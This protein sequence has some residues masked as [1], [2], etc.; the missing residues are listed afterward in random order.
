MQVSGGTPDLSLLPLP[1]FRIGELDRIATMGSCFAQHLGRH[2]AA[3]GLNY[4]FTEPDADGRVPPAFS[5]NYGNVYTVRQAA[6]LIHRAEVG[7]A[8]SG[9]FWERDGRW[10]DA[11]RPLTCPTGYASVAEALDK[12]SRHLANVATMLH[13]ADVLVFTLG[14]TE[15]WMHGETGIVYPSAPGVIAGEFE[16]TQHVFHNFSAAEV[17]SELRSLVERLREI[18]PR[19]RVILTVSPVSL[20][21]T[22]E[23]RHV[24]VSTTYS[25]AA[26]RVAADVAVHEFDHVD[27][28]PSFEA[29]T[30]PTYRYRY[31][32]PDNRSVE[33]A[34][35]RH[36]M[37][38]FSQFLRKETDDL[39]AT[40]V[41][42]TAESGSVEM[43]DV[44]CDEGLNQPS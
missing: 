28:L 29:I 19:M 13:E 43:S 20:A 10:F 31:L 7:D 23:N 22:Y 15:A 9:E 27:Y 17:T 3:N 38:L 44:I 26:L 39:F 1:R 42:P 2:L 25:K 18:N 21:A 35:V 6:Q 40:A 37:R 24:W 8:E 32:S 14:L 41:V 16:P 12:R 4:F 11:L 30:A 33:P 36:A 34:G 5:C